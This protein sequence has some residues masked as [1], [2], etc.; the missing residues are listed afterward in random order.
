M[1]QSR[2]SY[3]PEDTEPGSSR[4]GPGCG[5]ESAHHES[6]RDG[7][8]RLDPLSPPA[9]EDEDDGAAPLN[10]AIDQ[11]G[12]PFVVQAGNCLFML[13][14]E[15]P[16][17]ILAELR[18]DTTSCTFIEA[19]RMRYDWPREAFGSLLARVQGGNEIDHDLIN[20]VTADFSRWLASQFIVV[21]RP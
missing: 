6:T 12:I 13:A 16:E 2:R 10:T 18:F 8:G 20:R 14:S 4:R 15:A 1:G 9:R 7:Q 21:R 3:Q 11:Q 5:C 17:W 19:R